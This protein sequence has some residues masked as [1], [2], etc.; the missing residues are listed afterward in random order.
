MVALPAVV[1]LIVIGFSF[2]AFVAEMASDESSLGSEG[3]LLLATVVLFF[4]AV[5]IAILISS[6][7]LFLG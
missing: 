5:T 6:P 7:Q 2:L 1:G 3:I 4:A